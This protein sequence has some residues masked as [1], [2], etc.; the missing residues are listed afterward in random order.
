ME[1]DVGSRAEKRRPRTLSEQRSLA[2]LE[3]QDEG[4]DIVGMTPQES[5]GLTCPQEWYHI[6]C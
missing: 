2:R 3:Y 4:I 6:L 1:S 5:Q